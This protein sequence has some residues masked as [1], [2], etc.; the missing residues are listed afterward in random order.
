[1]RVIAS[2]GR[3]LEMNTGRPLRPW[4]PQWWT[5]EGGRA[6]TFGSD[7]HKRAGWAANFPEA[8]AMLAHFG[9]QPGRRQEDFWTR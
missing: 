8:T 6:V 4:I 5:E 7:D 1:M 9:F 2:S 3:P